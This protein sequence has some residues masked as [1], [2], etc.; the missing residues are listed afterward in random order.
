MADFAAVLRKAVEALKENT[1]EAREKIYTKARATIEAKLAAVSSPPQ[2][3]ERQRE[4]LEG[5]IAA[6][7][8]EY[9]PPPPEPIQPSLDDD[10]ESVL[11]DLQFSPRKSAPVVRPIIEEPVEVHAPESVERPLSEPER[12]EP[13]LAAAAEPEPHADRRE[14]DHQDMVS[15]HPVVESPAPLAEH[16]EPSPIDEIDWSQTKYAGVEGP[17]TLPPFDER[18]AEDAP[19]R[20]FP[21]QRRGG[22]VKPLLLLLLVLVLGGAAYA[23]WLYRDEAAQLAGFPSF[24]AL[25]AGTGSEPATADGEGTQVAA[26]PSEPA[27]EAQPAPEP[28]AAPE[29]KPAPEQ[30]A[31]PETPADPAP[32]KFTQRLLPDGREVDE[33]PAGGEAG[34]GEG[35]SV[36]QATPGTDAPVQNQ[37]AGSSEPPASPE[38]DQPLPVGQRAIFY[39]ERTSA[40][41]GYA[42]NGS[43]VWSVVNE[44]PGDNQPAEPAI[45]AEATI[46][47]KGLQLR[48]TIR[49]N[50][51]QS[52][53]ASYIVELIFLTPENFPGGGINSVLRVNMKRSEQDTGSPLLGIP[54]KIADGFFLIALSDTQADERTNSTLLR[55][56]SWIDIPIVYT[57][58]RRALITLE[59]GVPGERIFNEAL[60]AWSRAATQSSG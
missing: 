24:D 20:N 47:D 57:S 55:R 1:P 7:E 48:M 4:L 42:E 56:Q 54:A 58:G 38:T 18:L 22:F 33:G 50:T 31:A 30:Q 25:I 35:T 34:L 28:Q 12:E 21:R 8:A 60:D 49:R 13:Q 41:E 6:V 3:A 5:A 26:A 40:S 10:L 2:V 14:P 9:A 43:V 29:P 11:S 52:L 15:F 27:E 17:E 16:A 32:Q 44:A 39:E 19:V 23:G 53:P 51:D 36:A 45:Q 59:K 46:P 37:E